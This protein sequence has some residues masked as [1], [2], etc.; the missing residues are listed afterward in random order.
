M[1]EKVIV[2]SGEEKFI[3]PRNRSYNVDKNYS[4]LVGD[5]NPPNDDGS[6]PPIDTGLGRENKP[7]YPG[8]P[9]GG[10]S[11]TGGGTT[12]GGTT[13]GGGVTTTPVLPPAESPTAPAVK[14]TNIQLP[15]VPMGL[16]MPLGYGGGGGGG[17][18]SADEQP[19]EEEQ[20]SYWWLL[21][22]G[23]VGVILLKSKK[24]K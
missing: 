8:G 14:V 12:G 4:N 20:K 3:K 7:V 1:K 11:G 15:T 18:G 22:V 10:G 13:G 2:F 24:A 6:N 21:L 5:Q 19:P 16:G 23:L 9:S 17:G